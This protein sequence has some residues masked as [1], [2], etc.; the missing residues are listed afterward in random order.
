M[1]IH[2]LSKH[3]GFTLFANSVEP[4]VLYGCSFVIIQN[5]YIGNEA[6]NYTCVFK[7]FFFSG[8]F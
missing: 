8:Y 7:L 1:Y 3:A 5:N 6:I 2:L 4:K